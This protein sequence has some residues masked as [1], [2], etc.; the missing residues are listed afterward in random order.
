[1]PILSPRTL[2]PLLLA[3]GACDAGA[4]PP[5]AIPGHEPGAG[6]PVGG[7]VVQ[8]PLGDRPTYWDFGRVPVG[9]PVEHVYRLR[10]DDPRPVTVHD[11]ISSCGCTSSRIS[12]VGADGEVVEGA[13]RGSPVIVLPPGAQ[14][15]LSIR[16]DTTR[17]ERMNVD[18]LAQVRLRSD[19]TST[20]FLTFELHLVVERAFRSVP[21]TIALGDVPQGAGKSASSEVNW[22]FGVTAGRVLGIA[23][24]S[25]PFTATIDETEI[26]GRPN[27][28][29]NVALPAGLPPGPLEGRAVLRTSAADGSDQG[30]T[31]AVPLTAT[32]QRD[33]V[34]RP[35][36][37]AVGV[38]GAGESGRAEAEIDALV[39]GERFRVLAAAAEGIGAGDVDVRFDPVEPDE[40]GSAASWR[41]ALEVPSTLAAPEFGGRVRVTTDHP[42]VPTLEIPFHG[43]RR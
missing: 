37:L 5:V 12:Y 32:V 43:R 23:S 16:V 6:G 28:I 19:S 36:S 31:L 18:K 1:M 24:V 4:P 21:E 38:L 10:N 9:A 13:S 40:R 39:P 3:L 42:R 34:A 35:G 14:A 17:V 8:N 20:P 41:L 27:W 22:E 26:A 29:L 2:L 33:L 15:E 11:L 30:A 25:E 7:I